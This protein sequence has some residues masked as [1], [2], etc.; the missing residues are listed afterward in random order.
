MENLHL[1]NLGGTSFRA[2]GTLCYHPAKSISGGAERV[3]ERGRIDL[4]NG[5]PA[6]PLVASPTWFASNGGVGRPTR[7]RSV[8][9]ASAVVALGFVLWWGGASPDEALPPAGE[10]VLQPTAARTPVAPRA[11][12]LVDEEDG[13]S[14]APATTRAERA[15]R[16]KARKEAR[17]AKR[18]AARELRA[19][20]AAERREAR[21]AKREGARERY[22]AKKEARLE[23]AEER[24]EARAAKREGARE[25][26]AAKKQARLEAAEARREAAREKR[27]LARARREGRRSDE[28]LP[29]S[30]SSFASSSFGGSNGA[31]PG[32]GSA[33]ILRINSL[34]WAQV[35]VDGR[36]VGYTPQ[37]SIRVTPGEH[38]VRLVNPSF[39]MTKTLRVRV[40][41]GEQVTRNEILE[42]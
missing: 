4:D 34:P 7:W 27:E 42:D 8:R 9:S 36:M 37:R 25:R 29:E 24:R 2:P 18:E 6:Q 16:R 13:V 12:G 22:A 3:V 38:D 31:T 10:V 5:T 17:L 39:G 30:S 32:A 35:F 20:R 19:G 33:G 23:A 15:E 41:K 1:G 11:S 26:Y 40:A 14:D 21:A 28:A